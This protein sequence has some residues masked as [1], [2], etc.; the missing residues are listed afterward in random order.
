MKKQKT[1]VVILLSVLVVFL[2]LGLFL[3]LYC[4]AGAYL[5]NYVEPTVR[6]VYDDDEFTLP[7]EGK[8]FLEGPGHLRFEWEGDFDS[9]KTAVETADY[10]DA[11]VKTTLT[12]QI[13]LIEK[14]AGGHTHYYAIYHHPSGEYYYV[15]DCSQSAIVIPYHLLEPREEWRQTFYVVDETVYQTSH[16]VEEFKAFYDKLGD[17]LNIM[18][19]DDGLTITI[20]D[21]VSLS[22]TYGFV[23]VLLTISF[24]ESGVQFLFG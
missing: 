21:T 23:R 4:I 10:G 8:A 20:K 6:C 5:P 16:T 17:Q 14:S 7:I 22:E 15:S 1:V 12:E 19:T 3:V 18:E 13:L 24:S 11:S 2:V 9:L